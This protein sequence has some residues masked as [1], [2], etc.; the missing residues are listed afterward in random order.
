MWVEDTY[1][2]MTDMHLVCQFVSTGSSQVAQW[3]K[4]P[5]AMHDT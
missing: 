3:L 1:P 4:N 5:S 2:R